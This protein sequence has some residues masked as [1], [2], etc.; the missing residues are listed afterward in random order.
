MPLTPM[1]IK[2]L[3]FILICI[4]TFDANA[5]SNFQEVVYL[6][7]G[8]IIKGII[9]EQ[10]PNVSLKIKTKDGNIFVFKIEEVERITK[11]DVEINS[12]TKSQK[13]KG[14][15][16]IDEVG[17][18]LI[19]NGNKSTPLFAL[20]TI[21]GYLFNPHLFLGF[22]AGIEADEIT[23]IIP[24]YL[25]TRTFLSKGP[26]SP[27]FGLGGGY[28]LMYIN[29]GSN[30]GGPLG[31][32]LAGCKF[33]MNSTAAITLSLGYRVFQ[34]QQTTVRYNTSWSQMQY[35]KEYVNSGNLFLRV[36]CSF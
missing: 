22:G 23:A 17:A 6:K 12:N 4:I 30:E 8:S 14:F 9:I 34:F 20:H 27:Y 7:N 19:F 11:E 26:V 29:Q 16:Y 33:S 10:V 1:K 21:N 36:G 18:S 2:I 5:Q 28:G 32:V 31:H 15:L 25:E 35:K 3:A 24:L 13:Q